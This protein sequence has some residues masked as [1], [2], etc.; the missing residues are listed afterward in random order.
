VCVRVRERVT[1]SSGCGLLDNLFQLQPTSGR[2]TPGLTP[3]TACAASPMRSGSCDRRDVRG[4]GAQVTGAGAGGLLGA[5][6]V[7]GH[8]LRRWARQR[9]R[10]RC[11]P[12]HIAVLRPSAPARVPDMALCPLNEGADCV[13]GLSSLTGCGPCRMISPVIDEL[14]AEYSGKIKAVRACAVPVS[15][16]AGATLQATD[17]HFNSGLRA[18]R[19]R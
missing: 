13:R 14:A 6:C 3:H 19:A 17:S 2:A 16:D 15:R 11:L 7:P 1:L 18:A 10:L 5:L 4:G 9:C 8:L 12:A